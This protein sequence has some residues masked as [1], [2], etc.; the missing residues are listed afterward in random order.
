MHILFIF[1]Q[2]YSLLYFHNF[3]L[4][5]GIKTILNEFVA[6]E[7]LGQVTQNNLWYNNHTS[8]NRTTEPYKD[9]VWLT[10]GAFM[11]ND[12]EPGPQPG[13]VQYSADGHDVFLVEGIMS[14][15]LL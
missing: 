2:T 6:Y 11:V 9:G 10:G 3:S 14:V 4:S 7:H 12:T 8:F 5:L 15:S 1:K 13:Q